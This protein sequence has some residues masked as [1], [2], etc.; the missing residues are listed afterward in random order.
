[1]IATVYANDRDSGE[2][3]AQMVAASYGIADERPA[4]APVIGKR[5]S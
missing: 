4:L 1:M 3:A 2:R 5:I